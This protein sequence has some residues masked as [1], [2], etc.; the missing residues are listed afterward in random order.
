M[1]LALLSSLSPSSIILQGDDSQPSLNSEAL[2]DEVE[3]DLVAEAHAVL[4]GA[5]V[6]ALRAL[7]LDVLLDRVD[8]RLVLYQLFLDVVQPV[9]DIGLEDLVLLGVVLHGVVG[10]LLLQA[11]LVLLQESS[12]RCQ[13]HLFS[14]EVNLQLV[15]LS[16]L[17]A[18]LVLHLRDLLSDLLHLL[19]D[20]PL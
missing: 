6:V 15:S 10:H 20:A 13:P 16:E 14:V 2:L 19:L 12:Y 7:R 3:V 9:V 1:Q 5:L 11:R 18:H 4:E 17:I 8:L